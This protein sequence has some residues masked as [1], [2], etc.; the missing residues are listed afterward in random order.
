M[1]A[2]P[3]LNLSASA[4]MNTFGGGR[5]NSVAA[6]RGDNSATT[7]SWNADAPTSSLAEATGSSASPYSTYQCLLRNELLGDEIRGV[8]EEDRRVLA[9]ARSRLNARSVLAYRRGACTPTY[10]Q[11]AGVGAGVGQQDAVRECL[12]TVSV[13]AAGDDEYELA[14]DS[15][16]AA[17]SLTSGSSALSPASVALLRSPRRAPRRVARTPYK[18]LDAPELQDDFYL[19]LVDWSAS[20]VLAVGLDKC[21]YLWNAANSQVRLFT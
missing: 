1:T 9:S 21:V 17:V 5:Q 11:R 12:S 15:E 10:R 8:R 20:N 6:S 13:H 19:N 14:N 18:V 4:L 7:N 2:E 16:D 3:L